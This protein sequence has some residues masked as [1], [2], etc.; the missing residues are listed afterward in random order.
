MPLVWVADSVGADPVRVVVQRS[1]FV[2]SPR[3]HSRH[4]YVA[5]LGNDRVA[6]FDADFKVSGQIG[7]GRPGTG[8]DQ[9]DRPAGAA[10]LDQQL[11][12]ADTYK[13]RIARYRR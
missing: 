8:P 2:P 7:T 6:A 9:V 4:L 10:V 1:S 13:H 12:I 5:E 11:W 3:R